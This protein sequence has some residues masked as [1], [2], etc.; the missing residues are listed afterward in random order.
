MGWWGVSCCINSNI[1]A[2]LDGWNG[3]CPSS[4][5]K[6]AWSIVF[7]AVVWTIWECRNDVVFRGTKA[8]FCL[9]LDS[10]KFRVALWFKNHGCGSE[11]DLTLLMLD[12]KDRCVE[13]LPFKVK[14]VSAWSPPKDNDLVFNVDGSARGSLSE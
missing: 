12:L 5:M 14:K 11:I 3:F 1:I 13:K 4:L 2:W 7:F 6:R 8:D 9:A 10:I